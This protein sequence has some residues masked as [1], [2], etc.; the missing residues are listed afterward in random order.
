MTKNALQPKFGGGNYDAFVAKLDLKQ[1]T[2]LYSSFLGGSGNDEDNAGVSLNEAGN[3]Y[4]TG[5]T[6][7]TDLPTTAHAFQPSF[8]G[9]VDG[10]AA[11]ISF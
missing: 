6:T 11:R 4:F 7:S 8:H 3:L 9:L 2:L 1:S 10:F 5:D